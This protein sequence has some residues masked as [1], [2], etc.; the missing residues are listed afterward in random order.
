MPQPKA[1]APSPPTVQ[2]WLSGT[3]WVA[4][5]STMPSSGATT[6]EMPC[7]G[8]SMSNRRMPLRAL[9]S[10]IAC[11]NGVLCAL[12]VSSRPGCVETV[13]SCTEKVRSGRRTGRLRLRELLEGMRGVQLVQHMPV[14]IDEIAAV[15]A[16]R[17]QMR[18]PDLVEQ[19]LRHGGSGAAARANS[20]IWGERSRTQ[21]TGEAG[22]RHVGRARFSP[23]PHLHRLLAKQVDYAALIHAA[24]PYAPVSRRSG[25]RLAH[26]PA[27]V[28]RVGVA[29]IDIAGVVGRD[30]FERAQLLGLR[31]EGRDLAVLDAADPD[32]LLEARIGLVGRC[33]VGDVDDVVL[34]DEDAARPA[35]LLPLG[36]ELAVLVEDL[37]AAVD[38]VGD[39][40]PAGG[41]DRQ[42]VRRVELA[43]GR[44][45]S[46]PRP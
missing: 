20:N 45:P 26:E 3:A 14:D 46:C 19:R 39:E 11:R 12:V 25:L 28:Q 38:A 16:A 5:G 24:G 30:A 36:E 44:C 2:A 32:A 7:S 33:R 9:P 10:R 18:V 27:E 22:A 31:N 17:H 43:R 1:S 37:D 41:I 40:Q 35:E 34:V 13:W 42:P 15:G 6:W 23:P 8:S 4:P 29:A 21:A